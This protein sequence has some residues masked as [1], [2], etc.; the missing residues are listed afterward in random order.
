MQVPDKT[1]KQ[2]K[3]KLMP[4]RQQTA[5]AG[6]LGTELKSAGEHL[7]KSMEK[8]RSLFNNMLE[9]FAY[10]KIL[11]DEDNQPIDFVHLAVNNAWELLTGFKKE[12]IIGKKVT[13]LI[14][15]IKESKPDLISI[16]G[17]VAL[18]GNPEKFDFHFEP[19]GIWFTVS[20]YSPRKSHFVAVFHDITSH[21]EAEEAGR[22]ARDNYL[23]I[24]NLTGDII[25][26]V[27]T[28]GRWT[29]VNDG[30]CQFWGKSRQELIDSAFT[31]YLHPDDQEIT[32]SAVLV[33]TSKKQVK[34]FVNRQ[35]TPTGWRTVEWNGA[36]IID[37]KGRYIGF[38]TTG[39]DITERKHQEAKIEHLNQLLRTV[40][41]VSGF[42]FREKNSNILIKRVCET[43]TES[44]LF[45]HAWVI[46][47]DAA[48]M[49]IA[50][51]EAG[52]GKNFLTMVK[53]WQLG[54]LPACGQKALRQSELTVNRE[55]LPDCGDCPLAGKHTPDSALTIRLEYDG[56][57]YGLL[58]CR[59]IDR[60][61]LGEEEQSL[62]Q[63]IAG[64]I[65][66]A[67]HFT[68]VEN[69]RRRAIDTLVKLT[70]YL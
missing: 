50:T 8:Y 34:G 4:K 30:A 36:A 33:V 61:G 45:H 9:G 14:P 37:E 2:S 25:V 42:I 21:K 1:R 56:K 53:Q 11:V 43:L 65:A 69:Q 39:R 29:F 15:G 24:T 3:S 68:E 63:R 10:C 16:Y 6:A 66:F 46:L 47:L 13:E 44:Q 18:T 62:L 32:R 28:E 52:L 57:I 35:K 41:N 55:S 19:L 40:A 27:D 5:E 38:Q 58:S 59:T 7:F 20:V 26:N 64:D 54:R 22:R 31:D 67:L 70:R 49:P 17:K 48:K 51:A 23:N 12:D 60:Y